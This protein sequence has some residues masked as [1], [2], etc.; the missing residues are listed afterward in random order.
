MLIVTT[1]NIPGKNIE[2]LGMARG[3]VVRAKHIGRDIAA[4]FKTIVGGEIRGYT[5]LMNEARD[6]ATQRMVEHAKHYGADAIVCVRFETCSIMGGSSEVMA[7]GT[8]VRFV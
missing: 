5:E 8:A 7:Y 6:V 4:G 3:N 1:D 2:I